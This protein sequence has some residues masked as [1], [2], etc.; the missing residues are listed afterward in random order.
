MP[1]P[2]VEAA[3]I[4]AAGTV[5]VCVAVPLGCLAGA[6]ILGGAMA[7]PLCCILAPLACCLPCA[8]CCCP[9]TAEERRVYVTRRGTPVFFTPYGPVAAAGASPY[10]YAG[11]LYGVDEGE[12]VIVN[13]TVFTSAGGV[14]QRS[15]ASGDTPGLT[16]QRPRPGGV[17]ITE[18]PDDQPVEA[19]GT[20]PK[21]A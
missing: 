14:T 13:S 6:I 12:I 4:C 8:L 17:V 1:V 2:P 20:K 10:P 7:I 9:P 11:G 18:L 16:Q 5:A 15:A 21:E 3:E 19:M